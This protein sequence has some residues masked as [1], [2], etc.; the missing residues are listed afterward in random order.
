[1]EAR[2]GKKLCN[3]MSIF[4]LRSKCI[5]CTLSSLGVAKDSSLE[6]SHP[7]LYR[8]PHCSHSNLR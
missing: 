1:M 8:R 5:I 6:T 4:F 3:S 7:K 2:Q